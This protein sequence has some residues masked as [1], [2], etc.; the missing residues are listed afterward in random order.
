[1]STQA[2][3]CWTTMPVQYG[4]DSPEKKERSPTVNT[5]LTRTRTG[6]HLSH[7]HWDA[8]I[9]SVLFLYRAIRTVFCTI[10]NSSQPPFRQAEAV[11]DLAV[12]SP[13]HIRQRHVIHLLNANSFKS[14]LQS[15]YAEYTAQATGPAELGG[16]YRRR[17]LH[18][19]THNSG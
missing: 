19:P 14:T 3:D 2:R 5:T 7:I 6:S 18:T 1:M 8:T 16:A 4:R 17:L 15:G 10:Y 12:S 11:L 13:V 9:T